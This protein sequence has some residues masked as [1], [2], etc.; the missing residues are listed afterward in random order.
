L[1]HRYITED[2]PFAL[3]LASSIGDDLGV[4]TPV[5]DSLVTLAS[6]ACETDFWV[7]GRTLK[8]WGLDG[9]GRVG[10]NKAVDQGWW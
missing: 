3:V 5:I 10:L 4:A 8:T 2:V 9:K 6:T 1:K 7:E